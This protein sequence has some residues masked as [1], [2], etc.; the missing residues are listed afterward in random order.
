MRL[1]KRLILLAHS[2]RVLLGVA[3]LL[4]FS[5]GILVALQAR[6]ISKIIAQVFLHGAQL[7]DVSAGMIVLLGVIV[8]RSGVVWL[9]EISTSH[10]AVKITSRL[11]MQLFNHL[12]HLGPA[13]TR[14]ERSGELVNTSL[15][16][17]DSL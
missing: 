14:Q 8:L 4:G 7:G 11:R 13:Y 12:L 6:Q 5:A 3:V 10:A 16:G 1:D 17:I 9:A 2:A 15:G